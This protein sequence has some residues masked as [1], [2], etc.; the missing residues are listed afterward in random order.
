VTIGGAISNGGI[1]VA[2]KGVLKVTGAVSGAGRVAI[3]GGTADFTSTFTEAVAF[4]AAGGTL[5][6][7]KSQTYTGVITGFAKT[8]TTALDLL[9]IAFTAGKTKASYSGSATSGVL[10]VTDGTHTAKIKLS[11][12]YTTSS[13]TVSSDGHG[14]TKVVDPPAVAGPAHGF[15][16]A[17]AA[18]GAIPS[19]AGSS[20]PPAT[21][22]TQP[23]LAAPA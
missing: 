13:F 23:I 8:P 10:N 16:A 5:E 7:A 21:N 18:F 20:L 3:E 12:N 15:V 14:G 1:L 4:S 9:D 11:G 19:A 2:A 17:M 6:L 22:T